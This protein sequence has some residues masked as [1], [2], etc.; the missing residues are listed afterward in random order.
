MHR[1]LQDFIVRLAG[2]VGAALMPVVLTSLL[3]LPPLV[4]SHPDASA[5]R[6]LPAWRHLT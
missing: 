6:D 4:Q 1:E 5:P 2:V 3:T